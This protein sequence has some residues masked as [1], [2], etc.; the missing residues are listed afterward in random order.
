KK[1]TQQKMVSN[2]M[3]AL[4]VSGNS[5]C[6]VQIIK[7]KG[8]DVIKKDT[9]NLEY[10]HRLRAQ[11]DKQK[12]FKQNLPVNSII[13]VPGILDEEIKN[14]SYSAYMEYVPYNDFIE[15]FQI[16]GNDKIR[17]RITEVSN[18][19]KS[20]ITSEVHFSANN[21]IQA[22][23]DELK[24][25]IP[26]NSLCPELIDIFENIEMKLLT[27][28]VFLPSG[29]CHGDLTFSNMLFSLS[30]NNVCIFDFLDSYIESPWIDIVKIRQDTHF[31][32]SLR[33]TKKNFDVVRL[34]QVLNWIDKYIVNKFKID[35]ETYKILQA[36][37]ILRIFPYANDGEDLIF[38]EKCLLEL[39]I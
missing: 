19:I 1:S 23:L 34:K 29:N 32:W 5:G 16:A 36:V 28:E 37:N 3:K 35:S 18:F 8:R 31:Y 38:L 4:D 20:N 2:R 11:I 21:A 6:T 39:G 15:F 10:V 12:R 24:I 33:K 27:K 30:T 25:K 17:Q 7:Y 22:K 14:T 26:R 9:S 13:C